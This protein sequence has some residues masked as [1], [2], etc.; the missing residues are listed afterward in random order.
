MAFFLGSITLTLIAVLTVIFTSVYIYFTRNFNFWSKVGIPFLKPVP[1]LGN[2]KDVFL[3]KID[4][5]THLKNLYDESKDKPCIGIFAFDRP[6]LLVNDL[7]LAKKIVVQDSQIFIDHAAEI[8]ENAD[9]VFGRMLFLQKGKRW[10]H[11]RVNMTPIFT[12]GKMKMMFYL[13]ENCG[14]ELVHCL[15]KES[16]G[17]KRDYSSLRNIFRPSCETWTLTLREEHR[18]RVFENKILREIFGAKRDEVTGEWRK[19]HNTELHALHSSPDIIRNIKSRRLRWAGHASRMGESRNTYRVL[20]GRPEG[21]RPLGRPRRRWE[22][23]IKMDLREVGY[24]REWINL[25]QDRAYVR[26]AMN[27]RIALKPVSSPVMVREMMARYTTDAIST[28]ALGI[29][30]NSLKNP[31]A[32]MRHY[33]RRVFDFTAWKGVVGLL[34]FFSPALLNFFRF[35]F[36]DVETANFFRNTMWNTVEYRKKHGVVRKDLLDS[37]MELRKKNMEEE[38]NGKG[39]NNY[40]KLEDD[41]FVAQAFQIFI[42]GFETSS[43]TTTFALHQLAFHPE[44]QERLREEIMGNL[45]KYN[46]EVTYDGINEMT[47]LDMVVSETLRLF[48]VIGFLDRVSIQDY[49][50]PNSNGKG[51]SILPKGT[52]VYVPLFAYHKNPEYFPDPEKFDPDRFTEENKKMQSNYSYMPFGEGPRICIGKRFGLMQVKTALMH[53]LSNFE[54]TPCKDT[55]RVLEYDPKSYLL[56]TLND[57]ELNFKKIVH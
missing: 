57:I 41:I 36:L 40:L 28:C 49:Q 13:V 38:K 2:L 7:D 53:I 8:D 16:A 5:A 30:S 26:A 51:S 15:D 54:V 19:L 50:L 27:L 44:I 9:P 43:S 32:E 55:P 42:G 46:Q 35:K 47:Y 31:N 3:Q 33:M 24:D 18:L 48:P 23:N 20:V 52:T 29:E 39:G 11:L 4:L 10:K 17:G 21:K 12:S 1:F 14:K 34:M 56:Q 6:A 37:L 45:A 22:D 25:A